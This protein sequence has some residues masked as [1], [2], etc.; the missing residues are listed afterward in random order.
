M[1][2]VV[3]GDRTRQRRRVAKAGRGD[4]ARATLEEGAMR[5][6]KGDAWQRREHMYMAEK[7]NQQI[8]KK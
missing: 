3:K 7:G 1:R 4:R 8:K 5:R 6:D 2:R